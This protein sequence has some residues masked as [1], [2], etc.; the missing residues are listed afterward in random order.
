MLTA[1]DIRGVVAIVPTCAKP[2]ADDWRNEDTV[3]LDETARVVDQLIKDGATCILTN[4]T[5]G[6]CATLL[7]EEHQ[8]FAQV[9]IDVTNKRVPLFVGTTTLGT[10]ET[11]RRLRTVMDMGADGTLL[12]IPM[13]QAPTVETAIAHYKMVSEA[14]PKAS[15]FVYANQQAFR[16][17]FGPAFWG[18]MHRE[19]PAAIGAKYQDTA[20]YLAALEACENSVNLVPVYSQIYGFARLSP[21]TATA[22]WNHAVQPGPMLTMMDALGKQDFETAKEIQK[23]FLW[24]AR[25]QNPPLSMEVFGQFNIQL[26]KLRQEAT[27]YVKAGPMRPPYHLIPEH[28]AEGAREGGRRWAQLAEKYAQVPA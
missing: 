22:C 19:V 17:P 7:W 13:W 3:D 20:N 23:D 18:H 24:A 14:V 10:R 5:T 16:F 8:A 28:M 4:G 6:E 1:K 27:G 15:I 26:E 11:I 2:G 12:G 25:T 21:E 9:V